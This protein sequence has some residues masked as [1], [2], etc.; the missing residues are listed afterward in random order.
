MLVAC[1]MLNIVHPG[2]VLQ[3]PDSEFL[4]MSRKEKKAT[5]A[6]KKEAKRL[7]KEEKRV[8]RKSP[9][10][11]QFDARSSLDD[12]MRKHHRAGGVLNIG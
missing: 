3:G 10:Y 7:A 8:C 6:E 9:G 12:N 2:T 11:R 4:R 5:K 1:V